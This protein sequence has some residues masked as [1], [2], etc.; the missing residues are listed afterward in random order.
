MGWFRKRKPR[1]K[2]PEGTS[3]PTLTAPTEPLPELPEG[4]ATA[5]DYALPILVAAVEFR[6]PKFL[7]QPVD[8]ELAQARLA[9]AYRD[10]CHVPMESEAFDAVSSHLEEEAWR[11]LALLVDLLDEEECNDTLGDLLGED[12]VAGQI[13]TAFVDFSRDTSLLTL[14]TLRHS[15]LRREEFVRRWVMRLGAGIDGESITE[16]LARLDR[17]DYG[18]LLSEAE[19]AKQLAEERTAY[20]KKLN[21]L[22]DARNPRG[23]W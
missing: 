15:E 5:L 18:R 12:G 9:D 22:E 4:A 11:R 7:Q 8:R 1:A 23:K 16:S 3:E 21:D 10:S 14:A 17:L 2:K 13:S 20:L 6:L 19:R